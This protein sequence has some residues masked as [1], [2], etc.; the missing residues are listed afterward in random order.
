MFI[1][2]RMNGNQIELWEAEWTYPQNS[3]AHK[4]FIRMIGVEQPLKPAGHAN[5]EAICWAYGRTLGNIAVF[6]QQVI[7]S[8]PT[9]EGT[10]AQISCDIVEAGKFRNGVDRWWCRTHQTHWGK[11]ADL[12][13]AR[14]AGF[15][16]CA[17]HRQP[18]SYVRDPYQLVL[19]NH[20]EVGVWCSLPAAYS[21]IWQITPRAPKIHVHVRN[22]VSGYKE[23][24]KDFAAISI[25]YNPARDLF[26]NSTITKVNVTP[27]AAYEFLKGM[28]KNYDMD[29]IGCSYCGYP[30][31]DLGS[32]AEMPHRKHFCGNCGRD[33]TWSK[34]AIVSTP[35]KP[36]HDQFSAA[37]T[38]VEPDREIN[39]DDYKNHN[40]VLWS[41]TPAI[42]W[43]ASRP[44]EVGIHVH[45]M[46]GEKRVVDDTFR[47]VI[48]NGRLID[49]NLLLQ[50]MMGR[51]TV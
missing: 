42:I 5:A 21:N 28:I 7:G 34:R 47:R 2:R 35:L 37:N 26:E 38:Y 11:K 19:E 32:F 50:Q 41:S 14:R 22:T 27:T 8:F 17:N 30:H 13:A 44:Q 12:E 45:M 48:L 36:L 20:L 46:D 31:L 24:D 23:V 49:R 43:T 9:R 16:V 15:I 18:M 40:F 10:N 39:L 33:S 3:P 6:N 1:E 51:T 29:C 4:T 25:H